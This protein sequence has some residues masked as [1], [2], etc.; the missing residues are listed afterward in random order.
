[1]MRTVLLATVA[2]TL[3]T[4]V[5]SR[6]RNAIPQLDLRQTCRLA[7]TLELADGQSFAGCMHD[8]NAAKAQL[9]D[10]WKG[11]PSAAR[12]RC[13]AE[14]M[15]GGSPSYVEIAVC[16]DMDKSVSQSFARGRG[17]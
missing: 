14:T 11:Y 10:Q 4:P 3:A 17:Q 13:S 9:A 5:T 8:E 7:S 16:I 2:A 15:I 12:A 1:M 6:T